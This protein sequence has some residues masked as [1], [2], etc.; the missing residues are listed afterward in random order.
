[1]LHFDILT[2]LITD[3]VFVCHF[4]HYAVSLS[5]VLTVLT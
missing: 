5:V 2:Y 1:M 4:E 3:V